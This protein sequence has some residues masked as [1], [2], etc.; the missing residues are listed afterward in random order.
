MA[1]RKLEGDKR[2]QAL[3]DRYGP[4]CIL[5]PFARCSASALRACLAEASA[6]KV[7]RLC[8][9]TPRQPWPELP[10]RQL[11]ATAQLAQRHRALSTACIACFQGDR[12]SLKLRYRSL[13]H[14]FRFRKVP[15]LDK[16]LRGTGAQLHCLQQ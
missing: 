4:C 8:I 10:G 9:C 15:V 1:A 7:H 6:S 16:R 2:V 5:D 13:P 12:L 3:K 14:V 11:V